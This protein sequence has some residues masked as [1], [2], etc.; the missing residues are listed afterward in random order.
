MECKS[1][2]INVNTYGSVALG[3]ETT[4]QMQMLGFRLSRIHYQGLM[5]KKIMT[6]QYY[7]G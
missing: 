4:T 6:S 3:H 1:K 7:D 5:N 2:K